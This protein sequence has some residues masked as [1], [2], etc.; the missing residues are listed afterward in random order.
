MR[1]TALSPRMLL[2]AA[3]CLALG[4]AGLHAQTVQHTR[5]EDSQATS[6]RPAYNK[7]DANDRLIAQIW[8]LNDE[9]MLRAKLLLEGPRKSF[10]VENLS[11]VEALGI[12]ARSE[13]E[14]RK[15]AELFARAL[16]DDVERSLAWNSAFTEAMQRLYPNEPVVSS[17]GLPPV[18][19]PVGAA[20]ALGVPRSKIIDISTGQPATSSSGDLMPAAGSRR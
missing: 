3:V 17:V 10:S 14:R 12:H 6:S 16:H 11:P 8:G 5:A 2:G 18:V 1:Q 9:E 19:A 15:Y 7:L 13:A 20:D 4:G